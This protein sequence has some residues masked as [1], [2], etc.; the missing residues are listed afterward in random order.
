M[1][2]VNSLCERAIWLNKGALVEDGPSSQVVAKYLMESA[3][4]ANWLEEVWD[5]PTDAP[6]NDIAR[7]HRVRVKHGLGRGNDPLTTETPFQVEVEYWNLLPQAHLH[8]SLILFTDQAWQPSARA[9]LA[10]HGA[11]LLCRSACTRAY[12]T[13]PAIF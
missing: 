5:D 13:F 8:V 2:A 6:G 1:I 3:K 9:A 11:T 12:A 10:P 4:E 7:L